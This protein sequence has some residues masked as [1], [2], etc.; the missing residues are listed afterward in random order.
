MPRLRRANKYDAAIAVRLRDA[1][2]EVGMS[3]AALAKK[4]GSLNYQT[5]Q[6]YENG[7]DRIS[8]GKLVLIARALGLPITYF[9]EGL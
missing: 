2:Q 6:K 5:F 8:A 4:C 1:R 7:Q 3:L 9:F